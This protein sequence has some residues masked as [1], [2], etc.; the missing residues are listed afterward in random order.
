MEKDNEILDAPAMPTAKPLSYVAF[1]P[2]T[3]GLLGGFLQVP[4]DG[5]DHLIEVPDDVR[6]NWLAYRLNEARDGVELAPPPPPAPQQVPQVVTMRQARLALLAAGKYAGVDAAID[7]LPSP[8]KE[9]ARIEWDYARDV[10][11]NSP[12]VAMMGAALDLD[13]AALDKLFITAGG[14]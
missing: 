11:R 12:I 1:D 9:E 8:Q 6:L 7:S 3:G 14:L 10:E 2:G 4:V 5:H 13:D